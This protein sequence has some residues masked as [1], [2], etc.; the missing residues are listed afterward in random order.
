MLDQFSN[1]TGS[2]STMLNDSQLVG[3]LTEFLSHLNNITNFL[4][5]W[6]GKFVKK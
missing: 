3:N 4:N 1:L 5:D 6:N 2:F